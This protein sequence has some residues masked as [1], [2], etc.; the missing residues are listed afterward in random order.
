M[1]GISKKRRNLSKLSSFG[2]IS[3]NM[4][5]RAKSVS[6]SEET[7]NL[8]PGANL[9]ESLH[10]LHVDRLSSEPSVFALKLRL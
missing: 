9:T 7:D 4:I 2:Q 10:A 6:E 1:E 8:G 5:Y 3:A